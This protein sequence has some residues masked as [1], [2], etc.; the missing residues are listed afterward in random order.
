MASRRSAEEFVE[1]VDRLLKECEM[2]Y[3]TTDLSVISYML[4]RIRSCYSAILSIKSAQ[5]MNIEAVGAFDKDALAGLVDCFE[6]I[7]SEWSSRKRDAEAASSAPTT[8]LRSQFEYTGKRGRPRYILDTDIVAYLN[9]LKF[10][11]SEIAKIC[12]TSRTTI[13]RSFGA[14]KTYCDISDE[15]LDERIAAIKR[16]HPNVGETMVDGFLRSENVIVQRRRLRDSIHRLDPINTPL[17]WIRRHARWIYNVPGPNALW[18]ND[19]LHKLIRWGFVIHAVIDGYSRLATS[20]LCA[21]NNRADTCLR[22]FL[23]GVEQY[24]IPERVRG[25]NGTENNAIENYMFEKRGGGSYLRGPSVHNQRIERLHRDTT[26]AV[27][28]HFF[29]LFRFMEDQDILSTHEQLD[30]FCLHFVF[31]KRIQASLD[32][33]RDGWNSHSLSSCKNKSPQQLYMLGLTDMSK[34]Q[35][36]GVQSALH[37]ANHFGIE[38]N[39]YIGDDDL[40]DEQTVELNDVHIG[41]RNEE[42]RNILTNEFNPKEECGN[43]GIN[44]FIKVKSRAFELL[45]I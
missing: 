10:T 28:S 45:N 39:E 26:H 40:Q 6:A 33:F 12:G 37:D 35:Q 2:R 24:G 43:Y 17:R 5:E 27:L 30:I 34:R 16:D 1:E 8:Y 23:L 13:W 11:T 38:L 15:I 44:I 36:V 29:N 22:G 20:L 42:I 4:R 41:E 18:H 3:G 14:L 25:D 7:E 19:G 32:R 9:S 21:T 31:I